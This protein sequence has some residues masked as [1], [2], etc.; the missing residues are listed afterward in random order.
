MEIYIIKIIVAYME[1][2]IIKI[3]RLVPQIARSIYEF[4]GHFE[5]WDPSMGIMN[6]SK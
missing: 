4:I 6:S 2:Y 3:I 1:I 5:R